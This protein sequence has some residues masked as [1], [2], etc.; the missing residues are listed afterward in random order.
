[1]RELFRA[2][3]ICAGALMWEAPARAVEVMAVGNAAPEAGLSR[4]A[5]SKKLL[6]LM[7]KLYAYEGVS[8]ILYA[9]N[10]SKAGLEA[11]LSVFEERMA[12]ADFAIF[13]YLGLS[14]HDASGASFL[15]PHGWNGH[16]REIAPL[17]GVA[18]RMRTRASGKA[19]VIVDAVEPS[20]DWRPGGLS[21]GLG[22]LGR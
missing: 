21:P 22:D 3:A 8:P 5:V 18:D 19:L 10:P 12:D 17:R 15:V 20:P 7:T 16:N 1:M 2:L 13:Y 14:A 6:A 4:E 9:A 11:R